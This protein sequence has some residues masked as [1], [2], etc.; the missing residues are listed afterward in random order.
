MDMVTKYRNLD[1]FL[2]RLEQSRDLTNVSAFSE[3]VNAAH[4]GKAMLFEANESS[5]FGVVASLF[6][7]EKRIAWALGLDRL[8]EL[9]TRLGFLNDLPVAHY[10]ESMMGRAGA[11]LGLMQAMPGGAQSKRSAAPVQTHRVETDVN[12]T[13]LP[14]WTDEFGQRCL[15]G[16]QMIVAEPDT[17]NQSVSLVDIAIMDETTLTVIGEPR[18]QSS[19]HRTVD[20]AL[21]M[22]GEPLLTWCAG[23]PLP[24][25]IDRYLVANWL[26]GKP[27]AFVRCVS[28]SLRVPSEA[29]VI[30]EG[31]YDASTQH[32]RVSA[33]TYR[34]CPVIPV[35]LPHERQWMNRAYGQFIFPLVAFMLD[36]LIDLNYLGDVLIVSAVVTHRADVRRLVFAFWGMEGMLHTRVIIVVDQHVDVYDLEAVSNIIE[37]QVDWENDL[38]TVSGEP[39][40]GIDATSSHN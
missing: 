26:R 6:G 11:L 28:S 40:I 9:R 5:P 30:M 4:S 38:I 16:V 7:T 36:G 21:V 24:A 33:M 15:T 18:S 32:I 14:A 20:V 8:D 3:S 37:Q 25:K 31:V 13:M 39:L 19:E 34:D 27:I 22:G 12:L 35:I 1:E 10:S 23:L 2:A 29:D 17:Q